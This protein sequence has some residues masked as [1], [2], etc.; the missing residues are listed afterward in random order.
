MK[1]KYE[2]PVMHAQVF[3][4]NNY[5]A[6]CETVPVVKDK[7]F[8]VTAMIDSVLTNFFFDTKPVYA[9]NNGTGRDQF[10]FNE[11]ESDNDAYKNPEGTYFLE[12]SS[13]YDTPTYFLY[14]D[15]EDSGY[16]EGFTWKDGE[17][18]LQ[19]NGIGGN[20]GYQLGA[21][22]F[23]YSDTSMGAVEYEYN[24]DTDFKYVVSF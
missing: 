17:N 19:V 6:L 15:H 7:F 2:R 23:Y 22:G 24:E 12:W 16:F 14:K 3:R 10:Y 8:K 4:A 18:S 5:V 21:T 13:T 20:G 11:Y 9:V 1:M